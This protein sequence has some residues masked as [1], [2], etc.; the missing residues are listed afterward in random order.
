MVWSNVKISSVFRGFPSVMKTVKVFLSSVTIFFLSSFLVSFV[1]TLLF[2]ATRDYP[3][4]SQFHAV[5]L[6]L[7]LLNGAIL[8]QRKGALATSTAMVTRTAKKRNNNF[9]RA[10]HF[11]YIS[12]PLFPRLQ[13]ETS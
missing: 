3:R 9:A 11:L 5:H 4:M 13:H 10:V 8:R 1:F 6:T 12:L 2:H 7:A